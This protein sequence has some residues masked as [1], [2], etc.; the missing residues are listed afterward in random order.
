MVMVKAKGTKPALMG[1]IVERE[2]TLAE[3]FASLEGAL[4]IVE[5]APV[6]MTIRNSMGWELVRVKVVITGLD[7][8]VVGVDAWSYRAVVVECHD[9][10]ELIGC[11][12]EGEIDF[13]NPLKVS[14]W[15][16]MFTCYEARSGFSS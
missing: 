15:M 3:M 11:R 9:Q 5:R 7:H 6:E 14:D 8:D 1:A 2:V 16:G 4:P 13:H 10:P 12:V